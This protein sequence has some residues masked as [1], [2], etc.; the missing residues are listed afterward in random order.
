MKDVEETVRT[1]LRGLADE[2][3]PVFLGDRALA[4][5]RRRRRRTGA[6]VGLTIATVVAALIIWPHWFVR[7]GV[8]ERPVGS[9]GPSGAA[10]PWPRFVGLG[11]NP[12]PAGTPGADRLVVTAYHLAPEGQAYV[13]DPTGGRYRPSGLQRVLAVSPDLRFALMSREQL[14][15]DEPGSSQLSESEYAIYDATSG[16]VLG[17]LDLAGSVHREQGDSVSAASWSPDGD[18]LVVSVRRGIPQRGWLATRLLVVD[19]QTG[20]IRS[21]EIK[22]TA[23]LEPIDLVGWTQDS[24]AVV[25]TADRS[26]SDEAPRGHIVYDLSGR[27]IATHRW[28]TQSNAIASAG[29]D[30]LALVPMDDADVTV[31]QMVTGTIRHRFPIAKIAANPGWDHP[32]AWRSGEL[33]VRPAGC[34]AAGCADGRRIVG[35]DPATGQSR[36]LFTLEPSTW[37]IVVAPTGGAGP[38]VA[39][40]SW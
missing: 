16:R 31:M 32:I 19:V 1:A 24:R 2:G 10:Q 7:G 14:V 3:R 33:V 9:P 36:T 15:V 23:G 21:V 5:L 27:A 13:L 34:G 22:P 40:L 20:R 39:R 12:A 37:D 25:L 11:V 35:I 38:S 30:E 29:A 26:G 18:T 8:P 6:V 28:P 4:R 17:G